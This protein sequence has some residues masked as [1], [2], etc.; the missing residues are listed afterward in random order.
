MKKILLG[1]AF[2]VALTSFAGQASATLSSLWADI[3]ND[4]PLVITPTSASVGGSGGS[5]SA[6][7]SALDALLGGAG[8]TSDRIAAINASL[9]SAG[10]TTARI[11]AL[12]ASLGGAGTTEA[13]INAAKALSDG[14]AVD[15]VTSLTNNR[16]ALHA[17]SAIDIEQEIILVE[18]K[19][20]VG[21]G[22]A[23]D[24]FGKA[25][26]ILTHFKAQVALLVPDGGDNLVIPNGAATKAAVAGGGTLT[27]AVT[28]LLG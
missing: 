28:S 27:I 8:T 9:G 15:L 12:D 19:L 21:Y 24:L 23:P 22:G 14:G 5:T 3:A 10:T 7:T 20:G 16:N 2:A 11:A 4:A 26:S 25:D 1:T 13:R 17:G 18:G 6:D